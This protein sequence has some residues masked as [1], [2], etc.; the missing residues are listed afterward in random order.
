M[1][2]IEKTYIEPIGRFP[3]KLH[4]IGKEVISYDAFLKEVRHISS[5]ANLLTFIVNATLNDLIKNDY[6]K[7]EVTIP[8]GTLI[9]F[10]RYF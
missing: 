8:K 5:G 6:T 7:C 4:K 1:Q 2:L 3:K 10:F 9:G